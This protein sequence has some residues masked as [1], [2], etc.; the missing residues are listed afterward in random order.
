MIFSSGIDFPLSINVENR[1]GCLVLSLMCLVSGLWWSVKRIFVSKFQNAHDHFMDFCA[2]LC[3]VLYKSYEGGMGGCCYSISESAASST[4]TKLMYKII[5]GVSQRY[6]CDPQLGVLK[7]ASSSSSS[8]KAEEK[9]LK[10]SAIWWDNGRSG[11]Y[12]PY[13]QLK[14][15]IIC[16]ITGRVNDCSLS[17]YSTV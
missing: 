5:K 9:Q 16:H 14:E 6:V 15:E 13:K 12:W 2:L 7:G 10:I 11:S 17:R 1:Q 4:S 8:L 3:L